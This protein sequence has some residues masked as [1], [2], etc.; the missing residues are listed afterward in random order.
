LRAAAERVI[1]RQT[2]RLQLSVTDEHGK[3]VANVEV[4]PQCPFARAPG[5][6]PGFVFGTF[7]AGPGFPRIRGLLDTFT[8][9]YETG[10]VAA[11]AALHDEIDRINMVATG[12]DGQ[13]YR[14]FN[15][16]FQQGGNLFTAAR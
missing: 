14:V 2:E 13:A 3:L 6:P 9:V 8:A 11:A 5:E 4:D 1:V 15:V 16:Y 12:E 7:S 10:N